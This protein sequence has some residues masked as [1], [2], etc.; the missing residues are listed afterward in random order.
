VKLPDYKTPM[1]CRHSHT[2]SNN[3]TN[4]AIT[5]NICSGE[6]FME[7]LT[8]LVRYCTVRYVSIG[9][10]LRLY[11]YSYDTTQLYTYCTSYII[12]HNKIHI[13]P[14]GIIYVTL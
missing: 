8:S 7:L 6:S 9:L 10:S 1:V 2:L 3:I 13:A 14:T 12:N 4:L 5:Y 11:K